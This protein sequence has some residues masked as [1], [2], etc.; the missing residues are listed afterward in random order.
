MVACVQNKL[1][2]FTIIVV[3]SILGFNAHCMR[4][5]S[6]CHLRWKHAVH[7]LSACDIFHNPDSNCYFYFFYAW[8]VRRLCVTWTNL[9]QRKHNEFRACAL[10]V[11]NVRQTLVWRS[12]GVDIHTRKNAH[13][14][15]HAKNVRIGRRTQSINNVHP[16]FSSN[17]QRILTHAQ[18]ITTHWPKF[19]IFLCAGHAWWY[20][21]HTQDD[22]IT[23]WKCPI[24]SFLRDPQL[25]NYSI[26]LFLDYFTK[27]LKILLF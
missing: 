21:W 4:P 12:S 25:P 27:Q 1:I 18:R 26:C 9:G 3:I 22:F 13:I 8:T 16:A 17:H 14:F 20:V 5:T 10:L 24:Q 15:A 11:P 7:S 2:K 23:F 19:L 6:I